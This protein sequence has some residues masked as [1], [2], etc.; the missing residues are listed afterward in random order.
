MLYTIYYVD[1]V[2]DDN[3][4]DVT[5]NADAVFVRVEASDATRALSKALKEIDKQKSEVKIL[6]IRLGL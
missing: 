4:K 1:R 5:N 3:G 6:E 2:R